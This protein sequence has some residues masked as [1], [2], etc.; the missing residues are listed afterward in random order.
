MTLTFTTEQEEN[1]DDSG[2]VGSQLQIATQIETQPVQQED[3]EEVNWKLKFENERALRIEDKRRTQ[4][5][6]K[7]ARRVNRELRNELRETKRRC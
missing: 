3:G 1:D 6:L 7:H 2:V 5:N 4:S